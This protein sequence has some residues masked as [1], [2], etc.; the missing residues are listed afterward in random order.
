MIHFRLF[1]FSCALI[2]IFSA[3]VS[4]Q[5]KGNKALEKKREVSARKT[6]SG[7]VSVKGDV[8]FDIKNVDITHFPEMSV[9]F[10][11]VNN[12]NVFVRTL[13]KEDILVLE[14]GI[15]R[16]ILSLDLISASNRV[17]IDIVFVIDETGSMQPF[18]DAVKDNIKRF[19]GR[20]RSQGFDYQL[21]LVRF[22]DVVTWSSPDLTDDV[23]TFERWVGEIQAAGGGDIPENALEGLKA[24]TNIKYR[25]IALKLAILVTDAPCF[26]RDKPGDG[27]T[28]FT[29]REMGD[30]LFE[31][32]L[33]LF[34]ITPKE[35][36]QYQDM[37]VL[38]EGASFDIAAPFDSVLTQVAGDIT[39][40][41][42]LRYLSQS[43][44]APDSVRIDI[45]R[46]ED[47]QPLTS[48]KMIAL[49]EG[50][51]FVF[52]DLLF[53]P[54]QAALATEFVPELE[55]VV[56]LM[57]VRPTMRIRV[58]GHADASGPHDK[59]VILAGLR[60]E[61]VKKYLMQSGI[62]G[63]RLE[64]IGYGDSRPIADN[65][66]EEGRRLNRRTEFVILQK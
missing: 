18:I 21:G 24:A 56:R 15:Q 40:L 29:M 6:G 25:P 5:L 62:S 47:R 8:I 10:S 50:K 30:Y 7:L 61:A 54:N 36:T 12:R 59:N 51:R 17:P 27:T 9:I 45:L 22:T 31:R 44:L 66:T 64:S 23:A 37:A 38:T 39:S 32:E 4:A 46:S 41:Y 35:M 13:K 34:G 48:R 1:C 2:A 43:T 65:A 19:S 60:A 3:P 20:L 55:R 57:H 42:A 11:A 33:R 58:E 63:T 53:G 52:E 28:D 16:P 14:N 26:E 49:D